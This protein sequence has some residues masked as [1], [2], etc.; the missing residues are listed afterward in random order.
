MFSGE[1]RE[2]S[3]NSLYIVVVLHEM[4]K[5]NILIFL[6]DAGPAL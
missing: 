1:L 3:L 5:T 6:L 2:H 4:F